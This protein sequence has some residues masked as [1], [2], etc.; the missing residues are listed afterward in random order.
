MIRDRCPMGKG[1]GNS[2][3][4]CDLQYHVSIP[5]SIDSGFVI[6]EAVESVSDCANYGLGCARLN[7]I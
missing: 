6:R 1:E 5:S 7:Q 2:N 3:V 4:S